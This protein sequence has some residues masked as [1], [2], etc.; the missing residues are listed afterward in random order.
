MELQQVKFHLNFERL[1]LVIMVYFHCCLSAKI[2]FVGESVSHSQG[3]LLK[4]EFIFLFASMILA[5]MDL[6]FP[7]H[8]LHG[9]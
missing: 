3:F 6:D 4:A 5:M 8:F 1:A 2:V 7:F 9:T